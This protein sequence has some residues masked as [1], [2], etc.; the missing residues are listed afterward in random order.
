[1]RSN[2]PFTKLEASLT[3]SPGGT[4]VLVKHPRLT[5]DLL[6]FILEQSYS[7]VIPRPNHANAMEATAIFHTGSSLNGQA[8]NVRKYWNDCGVTEITRRVEVLLRQRVRAEVGMKNVSRHN[9]NV[10]T[11]SSG[12]GVSLLDVTTAKRSTSKTSC[13]PTPS[14]VCLLSS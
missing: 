5:L 8:R 2:L 9:Y 4:P 1:M 10:S 13:S 11:Q 7:T 12:H 14:P 3:L 6:N